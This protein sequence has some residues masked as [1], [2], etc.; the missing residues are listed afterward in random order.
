MKNKTEIFL[1]LFFVACSLVPLLHVF[2]KGLNFNLLFQPLTLAVVKV[3]AAQAAASTIGACLIG[4][5]LGL[6]IG[7]KHFTLISSVLLTLPFGIPSVVAAYTWLRFLPQE[8]TYSWTAIIIAQI[9]FNAPFVALAIAQSRSQ[10]PPSLVEAAQNLGASRWKIFL[11]L[12]WPWIRD[13]MA[14]AILQTWG[15]CTTSF[16]LVLYLGGGAPR[17]T[18]EVAVYAHLRYGVLDLSEAS[19]FGVWQMLIILP[20]WLV[21]IWRQKKSPLPWNLNH[22]PR[23]SWGMWIPLI[24][25]A[26]YFMNLQL[27]L[28]L[29]MKSLSNPLGLSLIL[30]F[31][32]ATITV[33]ISG[34]MVYALRNRGP[35]SLCIQTLAQL[36]SGVSILITGLGFWL[37]YARWI[38]FD[39]MNFAI[40]ALLQSL[41]FLPLAF[42][43]FWAEA[44]KSR[45]ELQEAAQN[46]GASPLQSFFHIEGP[47]WRRSFMSTWAFVASASIGELSTVL[48]F[49]DD[50]MTTLPL[51]IGRLLNRYRFDDAQNA[52]SILFLT[53][54]FLM[55]LPTLL[56]AKKTMRDHSTK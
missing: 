14:V 39:S 26:P 22:K 55:I 15:L 51:Y 31:T 32:V 19:C 35:W 47:R 36:P 49:F 45:A 10:L 1:L 44:H 41:L 25:L 46:L 54:M 48:L 4:I 38:N 12:D 7:A 56:E 3:T 8:L 16:I 9:F 23:N 2:Y 13:R 37:T 24:F 52:T 34:W 18:L 50:R 27:S 21:V 43:I 33:I 29:D 17:E 42:R 30:A 40:I 11:N 53:S 20:F 28:P 6:W 5:P